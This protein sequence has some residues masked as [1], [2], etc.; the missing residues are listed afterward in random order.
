MFDPIDD[1]YFADSPGSRFS[2]PM[3]I[4]ETNNASIVTSMRISL[5]PHHQHFMILLN[6]LIVNPRLTNS[7]CYRL[8]NCYFKVSRRICPSFKIT[9]L[10][11]VESILIITFSKLKPVLKSPSFVKTFLPFND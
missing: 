11:S 10:V 5:Q 7:S 1:E 3:L 2:T 8:L 6:A 4:L 9:N